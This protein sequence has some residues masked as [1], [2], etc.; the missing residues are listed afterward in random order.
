[1][2]VEFL[3]FHWFIPGRMPSRR[4]A[5]LLFG[6]ELRTNRKGQGHRGPCP[7]LPRQTRLRRG[8][9]APPLRAG[10]ATRP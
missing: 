4:A 7:S 10:T 9:G 2:V 3:L 5:C 1:V 8:Y 6:D